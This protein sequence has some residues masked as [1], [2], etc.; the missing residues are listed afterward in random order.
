MVKT[1]HE[2][3]DGMLRGAVGALAGLTAMTLYFRLSQALSNGQDEQAD[4]GRPDPVKRHHGMDDISVAGQKTREDEPSTATVGRIAHETV[5]GHEP[6]DERKQKLGQ[7]VH[8]GYGVLL[9][10]VYGALRA[11]EEAPDLVG[12]LGYGVAAWALG[13]EVMVPLLGLAE[14][15]TAHGIGTHAKSLG[16]HLVYGAA[17]STATH[18]LKR[19]M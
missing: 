13:D 11:D 10:G 3:V 2:H 4:G 6:D 18:A 16:A 12:G 7:A 15:P 5:T 17:T 19:V 9:G 1:G 8:W 14:G